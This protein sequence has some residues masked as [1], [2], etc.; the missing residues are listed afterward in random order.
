MLAFAFEMPPGHARGPLVVVLVVEAENLERMKQA[1]P[2][3][4]QFRQYEAKMPVE[5]RLR[6]VD[7]VIAYE[8]D[9]AQIVK[10]K[11]ENDLA[12]LMQWLE[13]GRV[14]RPGDLAAPVKYT[15]KK[16]V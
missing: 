10:F 2:Y 1:D 16:P 12:G 6:D 14:I 7:L 15:I 3:D 9:T 5:R 13:R 8:D 11:Q 4:M